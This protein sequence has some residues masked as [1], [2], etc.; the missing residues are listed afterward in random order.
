MSYW[1]SLNLDGLQQGEHQQVSYLMGGDEDPQPLNLFSDDGHPNQ[2]TWMSP[3]DGPSR[4]RSPEAVYTH[5]QFDDSNWTSIILSELDPSYQGLIPDGPFAV[6]SSASTPLP[7]VVLDNGHSSHMGDDVPGLT[8][9]DCGDDLLSSTVY[10]S[11]EQSP[12]QHARGPSHLSNTLRGGSAQIQVTSDQNSHWPQG[13]HLALPGPGPIQT[14]DESAVL[15]KHRHSRDRRQSHSSISSANSNLG[16][17]SPSVATA[18]GKNRHR[19]HSNRRL[20]YDPANLFARR[21]ISAWIPRKNLDIQWSSINNITMVDQ[22]RNGVNGILFSI[23]VDSTCPGVQSKYCGGLNQRFQHSYEERW[24]DNMI[25]NIQ[26]Y[27]A[28][29]QPEGMNR[30][31]ICSDRSGDIT[32]DN[33]RGYSCNSWGSM[34]EKRWHKQSLPATANANNT[35]RCQTHHDART[36]HKNAYRIKKGKRTQ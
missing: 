19:I 14:H 15:T 13:Q 32:L 18:V 22:L 12:F 33:P 31:P 11:S 26:T 2:N 28:N 27:C 4:G 36:D 1:P 34:T 10:H 23:E 17:S 16:P 21:S 30:L 25:T 20:P 8:G 3:E 24:G 7:S 6:Q 5:G 29:C 35:A 9:S